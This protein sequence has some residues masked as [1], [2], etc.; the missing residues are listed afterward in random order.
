MLGNDVE[1]VPACTMQVETT[2]ASSGLM[3]RDAMLCSAVMVCAATST[4]SSARVRRHGVRALAGD[5]DREAV[6]AASS[7]PGLMP[8]VPSAV[9]GQVCMPYSSWMPK[10]SSRPSSSMASPPVRPSS[11]GWK[12]TTTVPSKLRVSHRYLAA[13]SSMEVCPSWPQA[14]ILPGVLEA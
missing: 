7:G 4:G 12:M 3:L 6:G 1:R 8:N 14:C 13:P 10:R 5:L 11:L 2:T 9:P